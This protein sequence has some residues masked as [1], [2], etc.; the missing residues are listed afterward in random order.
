[1]KRLLGFLASIGIMAGGASNVMAMTP[2]NNHQK[3][4]NNGIKNYNLKE[5]DRISGEKT[6]VFQ[7]S[8]WIDKNKKFVGGDADYTSSLIK[9]YNDIQKWVVENKASNIELKSTISKFAATANYGRRQLINDVSWL[10]Q[11]DVKIKSAIA[12]S[13]SVGYGDYSYSNT[14][15]IL[16]NGN[17]EIKNFN[18]YGEEV[19]ADFQL[20]SKYTIDINFDYDVKNDI[21]YTDSKYNSEIKLPDIG[22]KFSANDIETILSYSKSTY[23]NLVNKYINSVKG[24]SISHNNVISI[25]KAIKGEDNNYTIGDKFQDSYIVTDQI[26]Y[27][28]F[29]SIDTDGT[30]NMLISY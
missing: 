29:T 27:V 8:G 14:V 16:V 19:F 24:T 23:S 15:K 6:L 12:H 17:E 2:I 4:D 25:S 3:I 20:E 30:F 9:Q 10:F 13:E 18:S 28:S 21:N 7:F 5:K 11:K 22:I 26:F 1:M